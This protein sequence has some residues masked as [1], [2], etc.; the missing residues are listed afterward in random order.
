[1]ASKRIDASDLAEEWPFTVSAVVLHGKQSAV[2][3]EYQKK[4]YPINAYAHVKFQKKNTENI[5][6][7]WRDD[8]NLYGAK[9]DIDEVLKMGLDIA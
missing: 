5:E 6:S 3:V 2:W 9:I 8:P 7:I 4:I 1:M